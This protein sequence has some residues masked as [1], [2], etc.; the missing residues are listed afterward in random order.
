MK[1][2]KFNCGPHTTLQHY[3]KPCIKITG[4][5]NTSVTRNGFWKWAVSVAR[6]RLSGCRFLCW[7]IVNCWAAAN[8][9]GRVTLWWWRNAGGLHAILALVSQTQWL[10]S[11]TRFSPKTPCTNATGG[12]RQFCFCLFPFSL[13]YRAF[14][15]LL[16]EIWGS[17]GGEG[18]DVC[19]LGFNRVW[20]CR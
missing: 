3:R 11:T 17:L 4:S 14:E 20:T 6:Q 13:S 19:L 15:L 5:C 9:T 1:S 18:V 8:M 10:T 2:V 16:D 7:N 12:C